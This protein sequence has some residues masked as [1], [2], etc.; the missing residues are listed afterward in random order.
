MMR[1]LLGYLLFCTTIL[2]QNIIFNGGIDIDKMIDNKDISELETLAN[3]NP[4]LND[5]NFMIGIYYMAGDQKK[6]ISPD[7]KKA[8]EHFKKDQNNLAIANYK[9]AELYYYGLGV[10]KEFLTAIEYFKK[11]L[12]RELKDYKSV[13]PLS[14]LAI[15]NV[16]LEQLYDY[17]D[18]IP[19]L[20][21]A[22]QEFDKVEAQMTLAFLFIEGKGVEKDEKEANYW[23]NKAYFNKKATGEHKAYMSNYIEPVENFNIQQDVK[24]Y[25]GV[26]Q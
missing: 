21:Q 4:Y 22:A 12:N 13:A 24:N 26:L 9:I 25:C 5:I 11:S 7:F 2:A 8:M 17:E 1:I 10:E 6:N 16:Y 14:L 19:F 23:L 15:S 18:A 3:N 20:M